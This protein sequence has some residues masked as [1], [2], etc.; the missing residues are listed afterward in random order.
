MEDVDGDLIREETK[1]GKIWKNNEK[2]EEDS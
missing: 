1:T 2:L